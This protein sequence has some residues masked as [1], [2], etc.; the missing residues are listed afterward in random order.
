MF[1]KETSEIVLVNV[2]KT[3]IINDMSYEGGCYEKD[4]IFSFNDTSNDEL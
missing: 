2:I 1:L 4:I 3:A